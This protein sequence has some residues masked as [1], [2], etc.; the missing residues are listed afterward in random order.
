MEKRRVVRG[1][2][3]RKEMGRNRDKLGRWGRDRVRTDLISPNIFH[4]PPLVQVE[5]L[6]RFYIL[7]LQCNTQTRKY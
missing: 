1:E 2:L 4:S 7:S 3:V 5:F 6:N